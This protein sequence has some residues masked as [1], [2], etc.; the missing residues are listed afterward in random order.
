MLTFILCTFYFKGDDQ[1]S[2]LEYKENDLLFCI[3]RIKF[4]LN[5]FGMHSCQVHG[6]YLI[7]F[8]TVINLITFLLKLKIVFNKK[9]HNFSGLFFLQVSLTLYTFIS[10]TKYF[11]VLKKF[12]VT[13]VDLG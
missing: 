12:K 10:F 6:A 8:L 7:D 9:N 1:S 11:L 3:K 4:D 5:F 2:Q 13:F